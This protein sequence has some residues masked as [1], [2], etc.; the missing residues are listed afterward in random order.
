MRS[1]A[2]VAPFA[3]GHAQLIK[4]VQNLPCELNARVMEQLAMHDV[5]AAA[6]CIV[7]AVAQA[8]R[9]RS[10][11]SAMRLLCTLG[12]GLVPGGWC[13]MQP[14]ASVW[15]EERV[16]A[17]MASIANACLPFLLQT[18][19]PPMVQADEFSW[20]SFSH[21]SLSKDDRDTIRDIT[22]VH[23]AWDP[24]FGVKRAIYKFTGPCLWTQASRGSEA[25]DVEYCALYMEACEEECATKSELVA[26]CP[27]YEPTSA[28][29]AP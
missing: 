10:K 12:M 24:S 1:Q 16:E 25:Y 19:S 28:V 23:N 26:N 5:F 29:F 3:H 8:H 2:H 13:M 4:T 20:Q 17:R 6:N 7:E 15:S 11:C 9:A 22:D 18:A 14:M 27:E 21:T